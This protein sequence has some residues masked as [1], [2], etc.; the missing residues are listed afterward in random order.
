MPQLPSKPELAAAIPAPVPDPAKLFE[1]QLKRALAR[2]LFVFILGGG[3]ITGL[4]L[5]SNQEAKKLASLR[6]DRQWITLSFDA[7]SRISTD[8]KEA[9]TLLPLLEEGLP[10]VLEVPAKVLPALKAMADE[11]K[12]RASIQ[13]G[14]QRPA[15]DGEPA[16]LDMSVRA[17]GEIQNLI[18]Y[19]LA[20]EKGSLLFRFDSFDLAPLG[21][22]T[23]QLN[24]AG[25]LYLRE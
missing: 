9:L 23:Y 20:L 8:E 5:F 22:A 24:L 21:Q 17:D 15:S 16:S 6:G 12:V 19:V 13:I 11:N 1:R 18:A 25:R 4:F 7:L 2:F 3:I 10:Q 14:T